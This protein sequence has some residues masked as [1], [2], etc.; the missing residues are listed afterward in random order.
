MMAGLSGRGEPGHVCS[1]ADAGWIVTALMVQLARLWARWSS[2]V[3][4]QTKVVEVSVC[5]RQGHAALQDVCVV[6]LYT[7][8]RRVTGLNGAVFGPCSSRI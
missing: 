4:A 2:A 3:A 6:R 8:G 1:S 7:D 5:K